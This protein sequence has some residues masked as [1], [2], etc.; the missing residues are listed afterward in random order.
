MSMMD[1]VTLTQLHPL[2]S[3]N[4]NPRQHRN[5]AA[6]ATAAACGVVGG[7]WCACGW[8]GLVCAWVRAGG[9]LVL[10]FSPAGRALSDPGGW[11]DHL[12]LLR[13]SSS[14]RLPL[15]IP[16][17][18]SLFS[19]FGAS[20]APPLVLPLRPRALRVRSQPWESGESTRRMPADACIRLEWALGSAA[21]PQRSDSS[22][23]ARHPNALGEGPRRACH[24]FDAHDFSSGDISTIFPLK[25]APSVPQ[26]AKRPCLRAPSPNFVASPQLVGSSQPIAWSEPI[27]LP[28]PI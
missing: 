8:W 27:G 21:H 24:L 28:Q 16:R 11:F 13:S 2:G 4:H 26:G 1:C 12:S 10:V 18:V 19:L 22:H 6:L 3:N 23:R 5:A 25:Y 9:L 14:L 20:T 17:A 7:A 15:P